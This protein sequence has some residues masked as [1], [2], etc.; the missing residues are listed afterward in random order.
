MGGQRRQEIQQKRARRAQRRATRKQGTGATQSE[1]NDDKQ[2]QTNSVNHKI[3]SEQRSVSVK[4]RDSQEANKKEGE[5][6]VVERETLEA[7]K[8]GRDRQQEKEQGISQKLQSDNIINKEPLVKS[9]RLVSEECTSGETEA[10]LEK[11]NKKN[12][13][14]ALNIS[15]PESST[16][17]SQQTS[18]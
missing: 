18:S 15:P 1:E 6:A 3:K 12:S 5:G 4:A 2:K 10:K 13:E 8:A 17:P 11:G 7:K 14:E 9:S 16:S